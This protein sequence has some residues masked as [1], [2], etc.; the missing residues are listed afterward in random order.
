MIINFWTAFVVTLLAYHHLQEEWI[1]HGLAVVG[2]T[3][4]LA[5]LLKRCKQQQREEK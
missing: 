3:Q 1:L 4:L 5:V 2:F